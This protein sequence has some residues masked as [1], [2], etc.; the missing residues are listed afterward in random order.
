MEARGRVTASAVGRWG[1]GERRR[2]AWTGRKCE[3]GGNERAARPRTHDGLDHAQV[4]A[5]RRTIVLESGCA[6]PVRRKTPPSP[7]ATASSV[8]GA[9]APRSRSPRRPGRRTWSTATSPLAGRTNWGWAH[10]SQR[11]RVAM[12]VEF[13]GRRS[14]NSAKPACSVG[15]HGIVLRC[16]GPPRPWRSG[17]GPSSIGLRS[18]RGGGRPPGDRGRGAPRESGRPR[19]TRCRPP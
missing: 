17:P 2:P 11:P 15:P 14:R 3:A 16:A 5:T 10:P 18:G 1:G 8:A 13:A 7:A 6:P 4:M 19:R 9:A 12:R